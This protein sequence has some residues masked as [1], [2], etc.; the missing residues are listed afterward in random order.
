[1]TERREFI[2]LRASSDNATESGAKRC[3]ALELLNH[4]P[5]D[6]DTL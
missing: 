6:G 4:I 5:I 1:M 2:V 3:K